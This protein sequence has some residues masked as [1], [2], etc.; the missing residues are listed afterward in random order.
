M[1]MGISSLLFGLILL[2]AVSA[3][4]S[5]S[6]PAIIGEAYRVDNGQLWYREKHFYSQDGLQHQI[7]YEQPDGRQI[8]SKSVDYSHGLITPAFSQQS[9][10][11]DEFYGAQWQEGVL[12]AAISRAGPD[13]AAGAGGSGAATGG[14]C[15]L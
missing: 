13:H 3:D 1:R 10:L 6:S 8:A 11:Y 4:A 14:G 9:T 5:S 7:I 12:A 15:G 2:V